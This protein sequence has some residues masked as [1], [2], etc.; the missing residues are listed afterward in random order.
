SSASGRDRGGAL[1]GGRSRQGS[2]SASDRRDRG[3]AASGGRGGQGRGGRSA[4]RGPQD[5]DDDEWDAGWETGTWDTGW[6]TD[7]R[8][9]VESGRAGAQDEYDDSG[10]WAPGRGGGQSRRGYDTDEDAL[11]QSLSTL[12]ALGAVGRPMGRVE[13]VRLLMRRRPAAAAMLAFFVL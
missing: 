13:R 3:G 1:S 9:S 10:F 4:S 2:G 11:S 7:F 12:A 5:W 6:A 8:P